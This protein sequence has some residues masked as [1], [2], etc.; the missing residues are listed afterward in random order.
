MA[1]ARIDRAYVLDVVG[2]LWRI[3]FESGRDAGT[4][5]SAHRLARLD[6]AG[7][8]F[9]STPDASVLDIGMRSRLAIAM[10]SGSLMRPRDAAVEDALFVVYDEIAG[11]PDARSRSRPTCT[12]PRTRR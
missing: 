4:L 10:G 11:S 1:T 3:D 8:R 7:R 2:N 5:A 12:M 6:A 9:H